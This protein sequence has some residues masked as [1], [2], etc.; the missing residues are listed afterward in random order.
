MGMWRLT[1]GTVKGTVVLVSCSNSVRLNAVKWDDV[2]VNVAMVPH[3]SCVVEVLL[4][5]CSLHLYRS[6]SW[7]SRKHG[8]HKSNRVARFQSKSRPYRHIFLHSLKMCAASRIQCGVT[9]FHDPVGTWVSELLVPVWQ[10]DVAHLRMQK[11][12]LIW[13]LNQ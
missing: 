6:C 12:N 1:K 7:T 4:F 8:T 10:G 11:R 5:H 13:S 3:V 9:W 2:R